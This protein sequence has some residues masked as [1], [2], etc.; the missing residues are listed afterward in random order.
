[1]FDT[2]SDAL[3]ERM[4]ALETMTPIPY[5]RQN[6]GDYEIPEMV[7]KSELGAPDLSGFALHRE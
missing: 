1:M 2:V 4:H 5:R 3:R 6:F 7:L